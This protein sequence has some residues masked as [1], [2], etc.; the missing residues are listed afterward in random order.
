MKAFR[1]ASGAAV[2]EL[3]SGVD[4]AWNDLSDSFNDARAELM[5]RK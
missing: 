1:E 2:S 4:A 5:Q 3:K